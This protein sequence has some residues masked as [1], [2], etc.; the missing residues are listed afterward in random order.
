M[1]KKKLLKSTKSVPSKKSVSKV[2]DKFTDSKEEQIVSKII[3]RVSINARKRAAYHGA[4]YTIIKEGV[5]LKKS[6]SGSITKLGKVTKRKRPSTI[7]KTIKI[8]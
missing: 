6:A 5:I 8:R 4:S 7:S 1:A 3:A 2:E